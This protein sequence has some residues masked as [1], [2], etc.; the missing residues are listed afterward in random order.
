[1][2]VRPSGT[3]RSTNDHRSSCEFSCVDIGSPYPIGTP[4]PFGTLSTVGACRGSEHM[5]P[6]FCV[7]KES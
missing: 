5:D 6:L 1:M 2:T 3:D 4:Y 7:R